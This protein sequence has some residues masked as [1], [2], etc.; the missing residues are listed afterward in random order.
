MNLTKT[1]KYVATKITCGELAAT[2]AFNAYE[3]YDP[4][5]GDINPVYSSRDWAYV[6]PK[7]KVVYLLEEYS[8]KIK[9]SEVE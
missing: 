5:D 7:N 8:D 1:T 9:L 2:R 4:T 6:Q 3:F